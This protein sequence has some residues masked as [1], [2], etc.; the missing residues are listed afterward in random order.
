VYFTRNL[1]PN[2]KLIQEALARDEDPSVTVPL[3]AKAKVTGGKCQWNFYISSLAHLFF[4]PG[5]AEILID[6]LPR[7]PEVIR[8][9]CDYCWHQISVRYSHQG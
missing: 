6:I 4:T 7:N 8:I 9:R 5:Q 2:A 3:G 1:R